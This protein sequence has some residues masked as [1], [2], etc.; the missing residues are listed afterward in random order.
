[1]ITFQKSKF[2]STIFFF[3]LVAAISGLYIF[4]FHYFRVNY[5][6][7]EDSLMATF[8]REWDSSSWAKRLDNW[9]KFTFGHRYY[10]ARAVSLISAKLNDGKLD[11]TSTMTGGILMSFF[12]LITFA[13]L[14]VKCRIQV[15]YLL[16]A[17]F[18]LFNPQLRCYIFWALTNQLYLPSLLFSIIA[19]ML[20]AGKG[21][22]RFF[23]AVLSALIAVGSFSSG[24]LALPAVLVVL[25]LQRKYIQAG[26]WMAIAVAVYGL[27]FRN[28]NNVGWG[29]PTI[30]VWD[31]GFTYLYRILYLL[32]CTG[33][34]IAFDTGNVLSETI[35]KTKFWPPILF[36]ALCWATL[37]YGIFVAWFGSL[38]PQTL[39]GRRFPSWASTSRNQQEWFAKNPEIRL[40]FTV[41]TGLLLATTYLIVIG[42]TNMK[43][44][45]HIFEARLKI[46]PIVTQITAYC[47]ASMLVH[48]SRR[49]RKWFFAV[50]LIGAT[51]VWAYSYYFLIAVTNYESKN[52]WAQTFNYRHNKDS[53]LADFGTWGGRTQQEAK[54]HYEPAL[55]AG[56]LDLDFY[57]FLK[58]A[59]PTSDTVSMPSVRVIPDTSGNYTFILQPSNSEGLNKYYV[60]L[61]NQN[62]EFV[63]AL[64]PSRNSIREFLQTG[65]YYEGEPAAGINRIGLPQGTFQVG[66]LHDGAQPSYR[67]QADSISFMRR[68]ND[69][70]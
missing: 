67:Y 19:I 22:I 21:M 16:P 6:L 66:V 40:F 13:W 57:D 52:L 26:V 24:L 38:M 60:L 56:A 14:F 63:L 48:R 33:N 9:G 10:Y 23:L 62:Y 31:P 37:G 7:H 12:Y 30:H 64:N 5:P 49:V 20:A 41:V 28:Y 43:D 42:R 54:R 61:R 27:Y 55:A 69:Y 18:L 15:M 8:V 32:A 50:A 47:M 70:W 44:G 25:L 58:N 3:I 39:V 59:K 46:Y 1:M 45:N 2:I 34:T 53:Y 35:L 51:G 11:L 29:T 68:Q 36:G 17:A 65:I 4:Y